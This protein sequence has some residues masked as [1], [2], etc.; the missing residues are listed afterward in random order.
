MRRSLA[1]A[2]TAGLALAGFSAPAD[3]A[4][5]GSAA[6]CRLSA[7]SV[8]AVGGHGTVNVTAGTPPTAEPTRTTT[9]VFAPGKV[10]LSS[11]TTVEPNIAG[12][13]VAG[14]VVQGD[15]LSHL[16]YTTDGSNQLN[17]AD[18]V[19]WTRIGSGWTN[20][21][22]FEVSQYDEGAAGIARKA[23][24][25]LRSDG[26]LFRWSIAGGVWRST[27]AATGFASVKSMALI[28]KTR[29]YDTFLATTRGGAL[30][31]IHIPTTSPMKPV[32]RQVRSST[33][34]GFETL[35]ASRCG[36]HGTLLLGIDKDT[37]SGYLYAVGRMSG[38]ATVINALGKVQTT[39]PDPVNFRWG[40]VPY[41]D[42]LNAD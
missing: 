23:A 21:T 34:Q 10:R 35:I 41:L 6:A 26:T 7:G 14:W 2:A 18:P 42:P 9:G 13:D 40:G 37:K 25:G 38:T 1:I 15:V 4:V 28:S 12:W 8:T 36:Q 31:S 19:R 16:A 17:P 27:G 39:F 29:T 5:E 32:V 20:F 11:T 30:Y 24:Y 33:W 3:A 22:A